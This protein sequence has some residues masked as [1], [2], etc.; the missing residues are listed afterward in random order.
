[1]SLTATDRRDGWNNHR[2]LINLF[3]SEIN[4]KRE[5][6]RK[7]NIPLIRTVCFLD[8]EIGFYFNRQNFDINQTLV[9]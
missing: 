7:S 9:Q 1:M 4:E 2:T 3:L 8:H 6:S 5:I